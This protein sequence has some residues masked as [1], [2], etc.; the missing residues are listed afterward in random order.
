MC[1]INAIADFSHRLSA[2]DQTALRRMNDAIA[3][4]GPDGEGEFF[5]SD[6]HALLG[7][8]RLAIVDVAGGAMPMR[9]LVEGKEYV[10]VSNGEFFNYRE[11]RSELEKTYVFETHSDTEVA[12]YAYIAW[13][14][15]CV[16]RLRG[17]F[18]FIVYDGAG[19]R[20][21]LARDRFGIKPLYYGR[22]GSKLILSSEPKGV[23][24]EGSIAPVPD[25]HAIASL[26][27]SVFTALGKSEPVDRS[28]FDGIHALPAGMFAICTASDLTLTRYADIRPHHDHADARDWVAPMHATVSRAIASQIPAEVPYVIPLS[29]GLD[30]SVILVEALQSETPPIAAVSVNYAADTTG[31][32]AAA[33]SLA[34]EKAVPLLAPLISSEALMQGI[35]SFVRA[36]DRPSDSSRNLGLFKLYEIAR[37]TGAKVALIGEGSD[38]L[39]LGYFYRFPGFRTASAVGAD[40]KAFRALLQG[41]TAAVLRYFRPAFIDASVLARLI[42]AS[43]TQYFEEQ[44]FKSSIERMEYLYL[45][46]FLKGRL[47]MHDRCAMAHGIEAR[48]PYCDEDAAELALRVPP[49]KNLAGDTEKAILREAF[50]DE[51]PESILARRKS[52]LPEDLGA[53]ALNALIGAFDGALTQAHESVW[54]ILDRDFALALRARAQEALDAVRRGEQVSLGDGADVTG[55]IDFRSRHLFLLLTFLRWHDIYFV[56]RSF[57]AVS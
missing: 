14:P 53:D 30:S 42:D 47:D 48:V 33:Q 57:V 15:S 56:K 19:E 18:A 7:S 51:L 44:H 8:R 10:I 43:V 12:L 46:E 52:P 35:D 34:K 39:N 9:R 26:F 23:L 25:R 3:H 49:E 22:N 50:S 55:P 37:T 11:L 38:E 41:R 45:R 16:E 24:A 2:D 20:L 6:Q 31:D 17:Q 32:Y 5:S 29:G 4:R 13:G 36:L 21:F 28:C 40:A 27:L 1:G 54:Q